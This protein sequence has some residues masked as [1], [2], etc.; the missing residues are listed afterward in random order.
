MIMS[1]RVF[2]L[3]GLPALSLVAGCVLALAAELYRQSVKPNIVQVHSVA[4]S[5]LPGGDHIILVTSSGPPAKA[6]IRFTQHLL[7]RDH[8][9]L[10]V[11]EIHTSPWL[12]RDYV[13]LAMALNGNGF[14]SVTD[15]TVTLYVPPNVPSGY[16]NYVNRSVYICNVFPGFTQFV[17]SSSRPFLIA[18]K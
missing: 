15:F 1:R 2:R 6:C 3:Y 13:P 12:L 14:N 18:L 17:E 5:D 8:T 7:Y 9:Q 4:I 10:D 11:D 16:W